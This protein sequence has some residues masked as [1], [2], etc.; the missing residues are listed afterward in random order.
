VIQHDNVGVYFSAME[1]FTVAISAAASQI[2]RMLDWKEIA[3]K[4][5]G[6]AASEGAKG[7]LNHL[8]QSDREKAARD[9]IAMFV[10]EWNAELEDKTPLSSSIPGYREQL[11]QL[12]LVA[13]SEIAG[14]LSPETKDVDLGS[15][16]RVWSGLKVDPLPENFSW[17]LVAA[18]YARA[19]RKYVRDHPDMR[20]ILSAGLLERTAIASERIAGPDPGFNLAGYREY[21]KKKHGTLQVAVMHTS[22]YGYD[23]RVT[24][25]SVFVPQSA[26]E[27]VPVPEM[28]HELEKR[29]H[30]TGHI[31]HM[32]D[33]QDLA[34]LRSRYQ[35]N[36]RR[37]VLEILAR[38]RLT[39]V[40][41]NPGSGK[42][43][44]LKYFALQWA[45][46]NREA[47]PLL[48]DLREY[49]KERLGI[50]EYFASACTA[51]RLDGLELDKRLSTGEA[52]LFLDGL[53]EIFD[54]SVRA[55]VIE[56]VAALA[57]RYPQAQ[58]VVASRIVGYEPEQL[59]NAGFAHA[60]LE[61]FDDQQ[62]IQFLH[63]WHQIADDDLKDRLRLQERIER[64]IAE[65][66][67]IRELAGNPLLLTM[68]A[69]LN[70]NQ[71]LPRD[72]TELYREASRV[73]LQEWDVGKA[74]S[75]DTFARQE[76]EQLLRELAGEMQQAA[77]GLG[78]NLIE[79]TR[80]VG[81]F[82]K[83]L[84]ELDVQ[85]SYGKSLA[86]VQQ[87]TERNFIL[88]FAGADHFSFVHRTFLE[89][90][91][92][93]WF[94]QRFEKKQTLT[95]AQ[96]R[97]DVFGKHWRDERWHEVL[98]L[99]AGMVEEKKAE[100]LILFLMSS[101]GCSEKFANLLLAA[102]CLSEVRNRHSLQATSESLWIRLATEAS[103]YEPQYYYDEWEA[104][105]ETGETRRQAIAQLAT[106]WREEKTRLWLRATVQQDDD[107]IAREAALRELA[108]GWKDDCDT[109]LLVQD[110]ARSDEH[111][112]VRQAA[113]Q[114]LA[115]VWKDD[116]ATIP[117]LQD[118][119][120]SD[121]ESDVRYAAVQ[122]LA[123][124]WRN[125]PDTLPFLKDRARSDEDNSVVR[126]AVQELAR[127]WKDAP[128]T[129]LWLKNH[130]RADQ[131]YT[132][133][134][135]AVQELAQGW[136][137]DPETLLL[138]QDRA[139]SDEHRAVRRSAMQEL[140]RGWKDDP[141]TLSILQDRISSDENPDVRRAAVHELA[142]GWKEYS[143]TFPLLQDRARS[144]EDNSV[145]WVAAQELARGWRNEPDTLPFL[146]ERARSD[147]DNAVRQAALQ[148]L[149]RGWKDYTDTLHWIQ[150]RARSDENYAVRQVALQELARGW[151]NDPETLSLL[152]D[153]ARSDEDYAVRYAVVQELARGW[154]KDPDIAPLLLDLA[155]SDPNNH[156]R[157]SSLRELARGWQK[158]PETL[159]LL[160]DRIS[161][162][163]DSE[164][165]YSAMQELA[166]GWRDAPDT[167]LFFKDRAL[168]DEGSDVRRAAVQ[169]L[170]RRW[171]DDPDTL[172]LLQDRISSD[173]D[174]D[175]RYAAVQELAR[176]WRH[177]PDTLPLLKERAR[178]DK[179]SDVRRAALRELAGG[180]K[181]DPDTL[182]F[183]KERARSDKNSDVRRAAVQ[184]LARGWK[185]DLDV[186]AL[187]HKIAE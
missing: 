139:R 85:D 148:E 163:V 48:I 128:A 17:N 81:C 129:L 137:D 122:A 142:R 158:D 136:K 2:I 107:W 89:Y 74:I 40:V 79:R 15:V 99:I 33:E 6:D 134:Y 37:A 123:R 44:L 84:S 115:R 46:E 153:R 168:S 25:W 18:N 69:I 166:R 112:A 64:A 138:L 92:A 105:S 34:E 11:K 119:A 13:A 176:G 45:N 160:R 12:L 86:L 54:V 73:L 68:M 10:H 101:D 3:R 95:L 183:L 106:V 175:V 31:T 24:L 108:Q 91:C 26:R 140:A 16:E 56:E 178:S 55:S 71:E 53:D 180:W 83:F 172:S 110:R 133:R 184:E 126:V 41:G 43:S 177:D 132:V 96:L 88:S 30:G 145:R 52:S 161:S 135:T 94:V 162:D 169:E 90:Y 111:R 185:N 141:D 78:G 144:D 29:L 80:L 59:Q 125:E 113:L 19:I 171:R 100:E 118:R 164:V 57:S 156:V 27:S 120:C 32:R 60:T 51:F 159:T 117:L 170:A 47:I 182:P 39:V 151:K 61:D 147:K 62:I 121:E 67:A 186:I 150:D 14:W 50:P 4:L 146:K 38:N 155:R 77:G 143:D 124:G 109:L 21:L 8:K 97:E 181:D 167:L 70:R 36:V 165:R 49:V 154:K 82:R 28:P 114:E 76:K 9:A 35:G 104:E 7:L 149:V 116:P 93:C 127:G 179:N 102:R 152:K 65:S 22:T 98:R 5:Q 20:A 42:S 63:H 157:R 174:S 58:I 130:V 103:R 1:P 23:R 173:E 87:L 75:V 66:R 187:H 131:S 72:R